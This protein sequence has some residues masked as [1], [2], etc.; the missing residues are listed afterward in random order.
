[1]PCTNAQKK[2]FEQG[3]VHRRSVDEEIIECIWID[4]AG[5]DFVENAGSRGN[6]AK[7]VSE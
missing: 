5:Q 4:L 3:S 2:S 6:A 1:M 7:N